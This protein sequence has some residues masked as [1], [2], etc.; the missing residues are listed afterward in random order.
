MYADDNIN[1]SL[2]KTLPTCNRGGSTLTCNITKFQCPPCV[3]FDNN[4]CFETL[5]G[6]C[7]FGY[8]CADAWNEMKGLVDMPDTQNQNQNN[9]RTA[10]IPSDSNSSSSVPDDQ[11][12]NAKAPTPSS[13]PGPQADKPAS[14]G[15]NMSVIF[16]IIGAAIGVIAVAVIFLTLVRRSRAAD[17]DDEEEGI[18]SP[19]YKTGSRQSEMKPPVNFSQFNTANDYDVR[20]G[21]S[22]SS[23]PSQAPVDSAY[24]STVANYYNQSRP[25][26]S[27]GYR[28]S[29]IGV[30]RPAIPSGPNRHSGYSTSWNSMVPVPI[31]VPSSLPGPTAPSSDTYNAEYRAG[32]YHQNIMVSPRSRRESYEF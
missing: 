21:S 32:T 12:K 17:D 25:I 9:S 14:S 27:P 10:P 19:E 7:P 4:G 26:S 15:S 30:A 13:T 18:T 22:F 2:C 31:E 20:S 16:A 11:S 28:R 5:N 29:T 1:H 6:V 24:S 3:A 23:T 8:N